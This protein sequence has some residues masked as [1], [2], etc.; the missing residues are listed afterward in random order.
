MEIIEVIVRI[1]IISL[2]EIIFWGVLWLI[3]LTARILLGRKPRK[4]NRPIFWRKRKNK[5]IE[6]KPE[7]NQT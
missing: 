7:Q 2:F 4:V 5:P 6:P 3:E 1:L